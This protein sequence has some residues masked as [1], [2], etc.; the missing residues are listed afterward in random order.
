MGSTQKQ[1]GIQ[2]AR[3]IAALSIVYFHSWTV[4]DR[5][6]KGT[7]HPFPIV[8]EYGWLAVDLFFAISGYVICLVVSRPGFSPFDFLIKR[9]FRLYP[10]WLVT[11]S[12]FAVLAWAWRGLQPTET[13]GFF[14]YSATLLPTNGFPFYDIGWSLQHEMLFYLLA[15]LIV[16]IF[17]LWGLALFLTLSTL[18]YFT[19]PMPWF[20]G[21]FSMFHS[22]FLAGVLAFMVAPRWRFGAVLPLLAGSI[23]LWYFITVAIGRPGIPIALFFF[24]L[25]FASMKPISATSGLVHLGDASYSMYLLHPLIFLVA[26]AATIPLLAFAWAEEPVRF[27][28]IAIVCAVAL[29][30]WRLF[31]KPTVGVGNRLARRLKDAH[32]VIAENGW[33]QDIETRGR[34]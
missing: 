12:T 9:A 30:S 11:L 21:S 29:A 31:E 6:P 28:S 17:R 10:L 5:Y 22:E 19:I 14:L 32:D 15:C 7:A 2:I 20:P 8:S 27:A 3:A 33:R 16:P 26:K 1:P 23:A 24:V 13:A 18:A 4:L 34:G 25:G